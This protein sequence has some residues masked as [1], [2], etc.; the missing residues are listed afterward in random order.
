VITIK[1]NVSFKKL[2]TL[3]LGGKAKYFVEVRT[4]KEL[5]ESLKYAKE[6]KLPSFVMG[7]GSNL[8]PADE[9]FNGLVIKVRIG[10]VRIKGRTAE[11]GAGENLFSFI[12]ALNTRGL[13]GL[14]RMAGIP[15][16]VGGALYGN[17]GAYGQE[18][19]DCVKK[20]RVFDGNKVREISKKSAR[21]S[22][23]S[24]FFKK[25]A[26]IILGATF[27]LTP[28]NPKLLKKT[29]SEIVALREKKYPP[30]LRCPGSFFKNIVLA[31]LTEKERKQLVKLV[32]PEKV[33]Y[34][35]IPAG[36][37]LEEVG[38]KG[39]RRGRIHIANHHGNLFY[40]SSGGTSVDISELA[41]V[42]K[43]KVKRKFGVL[44][45]EEVR[46]VP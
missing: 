21:F 43:K 32:P 13:A 22:Y 29:S 16:T 31:Q 30:G 40:N 6:K 37:L 33:L 42:L 11:V 44:L 23:R 39:I 14:E 28:K 41:Q 1:R 35:K 24:S 3:R 20:V 19:K 26:W 46:Y 15:G 2:T 45:E 17:A 18:I 38:A 4:E 27:E 25:K 34:G 36:Y 9:G 12:W 5:I 7:E 8:V 10:G